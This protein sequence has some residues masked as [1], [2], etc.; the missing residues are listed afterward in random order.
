MVIQTETEKPKKEVLAHDANVD[1]VP[2]DQRYNPDSDPKKDTTDHNAKTPIS[3]KN[4]T[5]TPTASRLSTARHGSSD[6]QN[7]LEVSQNDCQTARRQ[8]DMPSDISQTGRVQ[9]TRTN[10]MTWLTTTPGE[11]GLYV[12]RL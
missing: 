11:I 5:A 10:D 7:V 4:V 2:D 12:K 3:K 6:E 1:D 9:E 8:L